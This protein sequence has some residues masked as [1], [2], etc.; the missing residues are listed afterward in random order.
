MMGDHEVG[1][2]FIPNI[3]IDQH[4]IARNRQFDMLTI[5][6]NKSEL[7]GVGIDESTAI[8]VRGDL[9]KVIGESYVTIYDK[10]FGPGRVLL[11]KQFPD[12]DEIFYYLLNGDEYNLR[13]R[14]LIET[15]SR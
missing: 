4:V 2:G 10:S 7:L 13:E 14:K 1:L 3:V 6:K 11:L 15:S 8:V 9:F 12:P 5:L